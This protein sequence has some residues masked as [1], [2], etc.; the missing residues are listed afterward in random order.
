MYSPGALGVN[1]RRIVTQDPQILYLK[2]EVDTVTVKQWEEDLSKMA[3]DHPLKQLIRDCMKTAL[4]RGLP[5]IFNDVHVCQ[6][7]SNYRVKSSLEA[8]Q[9]IKKNESKVINLYLMDY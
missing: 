5:L 1:F 4:K 8:V 6:Q 7:L 9:G 3:D 2:E